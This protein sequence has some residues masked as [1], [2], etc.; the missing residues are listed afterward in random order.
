MICWC[1]DVCRGGGGGLTPASKSTTG[2]EGT[3]HTGPD[4]SLKFLSDIQVYFL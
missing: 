2:Y 4:V 3:R 1:V